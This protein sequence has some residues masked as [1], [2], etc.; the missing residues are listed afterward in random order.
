MVAT[1]NFVF[2]CEIICIYSI[3]N[4]T[5]LQYP[6]YSLLRTHAGGS[7]MN[8]GSRI[9]FLRE[10]RGWTQEQLAGSLGITRAALSHY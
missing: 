6:P 1:D 2:F 10:Q 7:L 9:A 4:Q 3:D 5:Q 8:I